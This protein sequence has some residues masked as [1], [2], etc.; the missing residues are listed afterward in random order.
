MRVWCGNGKYTTTEMGK[1]AKTIDFPLDCGN[2][3]WT[4][5][6]CFVK[7]NRNMGRGKEEGRE[8]KEQE[9]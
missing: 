9:I 8:K 1:H 6:K 5:F 7:Y 4:A 3:K 2:T